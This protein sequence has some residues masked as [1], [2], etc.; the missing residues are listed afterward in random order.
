MRNKGKAKGTRLG[1]V[2]PKNA[3]LSRTEEISTVIAL[4]KQG[5]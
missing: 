1:G 2:R 4:K 3:R 5:K